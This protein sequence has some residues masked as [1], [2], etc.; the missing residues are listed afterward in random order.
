[1]LVCKGSSSIDD[2]IDKTLKPY[3]TKQPHNTFKLWPRIGIGYKSF[4][5]SSFTKEFRLDNFLSSPNILTCS[6]KTF[7]LCPKTWQRPQPL[8]NMLREN[9]FKLFRQHLCCLGRRRENWVQFTK[10]RL[11]ARYVTTGN[12]AEQTNKQCFFQNFF[13]TSTSIFFHG[14]FTAQVLRSAQEYM[15]SMI[16]ERNLPQLLER[17]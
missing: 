4:V 7:D 14:K 2:E 8:F 3:L 6:L 16:S 11:K 13:L 17:F 9:H 12:I 10:S 1:M 15:L 5:T